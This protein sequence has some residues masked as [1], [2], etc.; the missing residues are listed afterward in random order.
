MDDSNA[1]T[2]VPPTRPR[3]H[4]TDGPPR[5]RGLALGLIL[6]QVDGSRDPDLAAV[7]G[8]RR[9]RLTRPMV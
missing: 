7:P 4:V 2:A 8:P 5:H 9:S 1:Q 6:L 3:R